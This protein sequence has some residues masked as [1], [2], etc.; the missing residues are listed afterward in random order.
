M[1]S[2]QFLSQQMH[3]L[4]RYSYH[5]CWPCMHISE[6]RAATTM[7]SSAPNPGSTVSLWPFT[8]QS[9]ASQLFHGAWVWDTSVNLNTRALMSWT[10]IHKGYPLP[11]HAQQKRSEFP[12][13]L[14]HQRPHQTPPLL[15]TTTILGQ[16]RP[17][18]SLGTVTS[19]GGPAW[20]STVR[21]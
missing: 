8:L 5:G 15:Q 19:A 18:Q 10:W 11:W 16:W 3:L 1:R 13:S 4:S 14:Y 9:P 17:Q 20:S 21:T 2:A 7:A 12:R 6:S